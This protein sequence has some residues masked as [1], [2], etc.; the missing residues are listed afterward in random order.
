MLRADF[1][2]GTQSKNIFLGVAWL[3]AR[4]ELM[5]KHH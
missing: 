4:G 2:D 5:A 1:E 3:L